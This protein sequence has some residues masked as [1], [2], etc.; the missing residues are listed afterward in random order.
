MSDRTI[1][2]ERA[3]AARIA[4]EEAAVR[5]ESYSAN[6]LYMQALKRGARIVREMKDEISKTLIVVGDEMSDTSNTSG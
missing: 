2:L 4:L 1:E 3:D 6:S 5:L